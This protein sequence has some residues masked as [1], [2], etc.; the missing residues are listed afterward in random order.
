MLYRGLLLAVVAIAGVACAPAPVVD[1]SNFSDVSGLEPPLGQQAQAPAG[2][3]MFAVY[4]YWHRKGAVFTD[5]NRQV[6]GEGAVFVDAG[7]A[8][9][10]AT[11]QND[12]VYCSDKLMYIDPL[13]G[14]YKTACFSDETGDGLFDHVRVAPESSWIKQPLSPRLPYKTQ[15]VVVP[16]GGAFRY[17]LIYQG[18]AN[19]TLSLRF[20]E[21]KGGDFDRPM[22]TLDM[23]Y[24]VDAFPTTITFRNL[25]A[26]VLAADNHKI[27]YR[28]LSGF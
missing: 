11:V 18:F 28:I 2:G 4:N 13:I 20:L 27:V 22:V 17:E 5:S 25:K 24:A 21:Y 26:E 8:V 23:S 7:D 16:H 1:K 19:N 14:A 15:D 6:V 12:P 3:R 9:F 10:P